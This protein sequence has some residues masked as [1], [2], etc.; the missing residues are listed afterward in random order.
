MQD[1]VKMFFINANEFSTLLQ[2]IEHRGT[3]ISRQKN[4]CIGCASFE[5]FS[6]FGSAIALNVDFFLRIYTICCQSKA[7]ISVDTAADRTKIHSF[8][9]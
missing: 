4:L 9:A 5:S 8:T 6:S 2:H 7:S 1:L 3:G